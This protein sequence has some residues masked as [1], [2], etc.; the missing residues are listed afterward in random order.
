[1]SRVGGKAQIPAMKQI[2]GSL[3]LDLAAFREL[4]AF[5]QLG[6]DLDKATQAQLDRGYRMVEILK[7]PQFKPMH[8]ADQVMSIYAGTKGYLDK[9]P[10]RQV[11]A[12]EEQF[13]RFVREQRPEVRNALIKERKLS[14]AI[15]QQLKSAIEAFGQ[16]YKAPTV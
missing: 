3:R 13:L 15:E 11:A 14:P 7:Q 9:V 8:V 2:A 4:E 6:T 5:A 10:I 16:V 1:V 12:W